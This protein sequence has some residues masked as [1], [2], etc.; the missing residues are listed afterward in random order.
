[1]Y[2]AMLGSHRP[3][4]SSGSFQGI[5]SDLKSVKHFVNQN[6]RD[7]KQLVFDVEIDSILASWESLGRRGEILLI[8]ARQCN[9]NA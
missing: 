2:L 9:W 4:V 6:L 1:M 5:T 7:P 3:Y 8:N